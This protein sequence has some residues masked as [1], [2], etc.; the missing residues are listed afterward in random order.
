[1]AREKGKGKTIH[2]VDEWDQINNLNVL[3]IVES[4]Y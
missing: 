3:G 1:M 4:Y 2:K